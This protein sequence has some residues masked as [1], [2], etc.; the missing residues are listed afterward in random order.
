LIQDQ[1]H[2]ANCPKVAA[3]F[4]TLDGQSSHK[5]KA[6]LFITTSQS[7]LSA[8]AALI[9]LYI[10]RPASASISSALGFPLSS[11]LT[12]S[13]ALCALSI[14][15]A[16]PCAFAA[17]GHLS[18]PA[19]VL[20][21]SCKL[22]PV[23]IMNVLVYRRKFALH[24]YVVVGMVTAGIAIFMWFGDEKK[25][26]SHSGSAN[27]S[28][29]L[30]LAYL[31]LNLTLDGLTNSTQDAIFSRFKSLT[32]QQMMLSL[33]VACTLLNLPLLLLPLPYIPVLHEGA[34][35]RA[36]LSAALEFIQGHKGV[37]N[38]ILAYGATG[39]LGQLFI[40]ETLAHFGSLTL[41]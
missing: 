22:V 21:K 32:G 11:D 19:L 41:V 2:E 17:L 12:R 5:F 26:K 23:L 33:N 24:K 29:L 40:F 6:S 7:F 14:T 31:L 37:A 9:Y 30:G 15:L 27:A 36:E 28:P 34:P 3:P 4:E 13:Y 25:R 39:A 35:G 8:G 18:Y 10:R 16:A 1:Y 38:A 20:A